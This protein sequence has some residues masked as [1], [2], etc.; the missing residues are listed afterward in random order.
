MEFMIHIQVGDKRFRML[1]TQVLAGPALEQFR[2]A[3]P[4]NP[5]NYIVLQSNRP[6][7]RGRGLRHRR[8]NWKVLSGNVYNQS[9]L[10]KTIAQLELYLE[11]FA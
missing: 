8:I 10:R 5:G 1:V 11:N 7:L 9:A 4:N 6:L 3:A 2:I